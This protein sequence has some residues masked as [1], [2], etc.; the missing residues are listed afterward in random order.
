MRSHSNQR[1]SKKRFRWIFLIVLYKF[2]IDYDNK[3]IRSISLTSFEKKK[4]KLS[5]TLKKSTLVKIDSE[6][7]KFRE[8]IM[9]ERREN[10]EVMNAMSLD[11]FLNQIRAPILK[12]EKIC[13]PNWPIF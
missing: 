7:E 13:V 9:T 2:T 10:E 8:I 11:E 1:H 3:R 5:A 4:T 6:A 12:S